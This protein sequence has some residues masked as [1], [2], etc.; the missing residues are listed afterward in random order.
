MLHGYID[1]PTIYFFEEKN[2]W[3]GSIFEQ[4]NYR[5]M[6]ID[7]DD[8]KELYAVVW[9]GLKCFDL[10]DNA[11]YVAEFHEELSENGLKIITEKINQ[12][13]DDFKNKS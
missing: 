10:I 9:Y 13:V 4:F 8:S 7:N 2:I 11:D 12:A 3:T 1:I 6:R 5:I